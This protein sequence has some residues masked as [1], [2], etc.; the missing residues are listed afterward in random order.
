M[1]SVMPG[2]RTGMTIDMEPAASRMADLVRA[3]PTD[4]LGRPTPCGR[5]V[6]ADLLDHI[7][8]VA[9]GFTQAADKTVPADS[10]GVAD[11]DGARLAPDWQQS[12]P[13]ALEGLVAAWRRPG[14]FE[15][16][17]RAGGI[18]LPAEVAAVVAVEELTVH[19]WDL[20]TALGLPFSPTDS[21][22]ATALGFLEPF[23][24]PESADQRGTAFA[25]AIFLDESA[26]GIHRAVALS[27][28]DVSWTPPAG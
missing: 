23:S 27:G 19:G 8:G 4:A 28:R 3:V 24:G 17:T 16:V 7:S 21:D 14:A 10:V 25:P 26:P 2:R 20:A 1:S 12:I 6:V 15:G 13:L 5:Y 9:D 11:G 22:V 18:D